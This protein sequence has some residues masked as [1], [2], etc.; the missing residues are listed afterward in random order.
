[1]EEQPIGS[2]GV[3]EDVLEAKLFQSIVTN[4]D[5]NLDSSSDHYD[6]E[7]MAVID[8][9]SKYTG[10]YSNGMFEGKG[11]FRWKDG[12]Q[13]EGD[14]KKG[15]VEGEGEYN[16]L[17]GST[18]SGS[19]VYFKRQGTGNFRGSSGQVYQGTWKNGL[20]DGTGTLF[21]DEAQTV[22]YKG[23]WRG[24]RRHGFGVM[25]YP[26]GNS[27]EG[28]WRDDK[29]CGR[30]VLVWLDRNEVY[31][32]QWEHDLANGDGEHYWGEGPLPQKTIQRQTCNFYRG[33]FKDGKRNGNGTFFYANGSQYTGEWRDNTKHGQG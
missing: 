30:G 17:D 32:G 19:L 5:G 24:G 11:L 12:V 16:W 28:E 26:S 29:K 1:M 15:Y 2:R 20:R 25:T 4:Y 31:I 13:Y 18:Y 14:F 10:A 9:D 27:Y 6:G 3:F 7:G 33:S 23:E 8:N 21:Y 22:S